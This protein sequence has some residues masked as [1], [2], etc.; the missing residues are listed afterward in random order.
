MLKTSVLVS[1]LVTLYNIFKKSTVYKIIESIFNFFGNMFCGTAFFRC[2]RAAGGE[3]PRENSLFYKLIKKAGGTVF[4]VSEKIV[5]ISKSGFIYKSIKR[6]FEGSII[7]NPENFLLLGIFAMFICPHE[8][9]N[10]GY[11][12]I[13]SIV[14]ALLYILSPRENAFGRNGERI[15]LPF[16]LFAFT[17]L[18]SVMISADIKDSVRNKLIAGKESAFLSHYLGT[19]CRSAPINTNLDDYVTGERDSA[20]LSA[21]MTSL[22]LFKLMEKFSL[23]GQSIIEPSQ[24]TEKISVKVIEVNSISEI[25]CDENSVADVEFDGAEFARFYVYTTESV[26]IAKD[27]KVFC[28]AYNSVKI[29]SAQKLFTLKVVCKFI[30]L[31]EKAELVIMQIIII[32]TTI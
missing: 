13:Y 18:L 15:W 30:L 31:R 25:I 6:L 7:L 9:W 24:S 12:L 3:L 29:G 27:K 19:I 17:V 22:E 16:I 8:V 2:I 5:N 26:Y 10:N 23:Q 11:G 14:L 32:G 21:L 28:D 1:F 4:S 20:N